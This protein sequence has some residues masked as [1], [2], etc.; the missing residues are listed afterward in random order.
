MIDLEPP[1]GMGSE[2]HVVVDDFICIPATKA[3]VVTRIAMMNLAEIDVK[4]IIA[5]FFELLKKS[6]LVELKLS[7]KSKAI[8]FCV[9]RNCY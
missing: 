7:N 3:L 4:A 2:R 6:G 5:S 8:E 1:H 9:E